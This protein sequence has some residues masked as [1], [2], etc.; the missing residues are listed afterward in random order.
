M[1]EYQLGLVQISLLCTYQ[2]MQNHSWMKITTLLL[3]LI[4][5]SRQ[6][7]YA[8]IFFFPLQKLRF[9]HHNCVC[10]EYWIRIAY[11][12]SMWPLIMPTGPPL[13]S[14][15][16]EKMCT[17]NPNVLQQNNNRRNNNERNEFLSGGRM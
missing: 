13:K 4:G 2:G 15:S 12:V 14:V 8:N 1:K 10:V 16:A 9:L 7:Y 17:L 5:N 3:S 11:K 6:H